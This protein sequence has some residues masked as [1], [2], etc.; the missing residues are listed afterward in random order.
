MPNRF[1]AFLRVLAA[2][3]L[4]LLGTA[5]IAFLWHRELT[6]TAIL[7]ALLGAI[8]IIIALGLFGQSRFS[9]FL[10]ILIPAAAAAVL[11]YT[12]PQP[13]QAQQMRMGL[14]L[15]VAFLSAVVLW[16]VRNIPSE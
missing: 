2:S 13:E 4:C 12:L 9:L 3:V 10:A 14:N 1:I 16:N 11:Y 8:Y 6:T 5:H 7:D 15:S